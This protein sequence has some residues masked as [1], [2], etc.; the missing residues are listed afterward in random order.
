MPPEEI[1]PEKPIQALDARLAKGEI[2]VE[3]YREIKAELQK[4]TTLDAGEKYEIAYGLL[5]VCA[6]LTIVWPA[7]IIVNWSDIG[8]KDRLIFVF[9][10]GLSISGGV[11]LFLRQKLG[12]YLANT[13][14]VLIWILG[15]GVY[16]TQRDRLFAEI[17]PPFFKTL[18]RWVLPLIALL[19]LN[20]SQR[21]KA[22]IFDQ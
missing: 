2:S 6:A 13:A 8:D 9:L 11:L 1:D 19:Y 12:Y 20:L 22:E 15:A 3:Q 14:L 7:H 10:I 4:G 5:A 17:D 21:L 16:M 18:G